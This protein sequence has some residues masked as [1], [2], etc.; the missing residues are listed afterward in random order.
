MV[1]TQDVEP[2]RAPAARSR[3]GRRSPA[4][5]APGR[6]ARRLERRTQPRRCSSSCATAW[7]R[8]SLSTLLGTRT[9]SGKSV[10][11]GVPDSNGVSPSRPSCS[12]SDSASAGASRPRS[13]GP[14]QPAFASWPARRRHRERQRLTRACRRRSKRHRHSPAPAGRGRSVASSRLRRAGSSVFQTMLPTGDGG[15]SSRRR[16]RRSA[17]PVRPPRGDEFDL[18][19]TPAALL[20]LSRDAPRRRRRRRRA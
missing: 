7:R 17:P 12:R 5:V 16:G 4:A 6:R 13:S 19:N 2:R 11:H 8:R 10:C 15:E 1:R 14:A 18:L 3:D 9:G 20:V